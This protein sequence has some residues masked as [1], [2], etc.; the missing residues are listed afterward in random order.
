MNHHFLVRNAL[1]AAVLIGSAACASADS[2]TYAF[3]TTQ[4]NFSFTEPNLI[5]TD[6]PFSMAPFTLS[7][8]TYTAAF[9][10]TGGGSTL[11]VFSNSA[12]TGSCSTVVGGGGTAIILLFSN[13]PTNV[14]TFPAIG[15]ESLTITQTP[16]PASL[17][18]LGTGALGLLGTIRRRLLG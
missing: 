18:L 7:S 6:G 3:T 9:F 2:F 12:I 10:C 1:I 17:V 11:F 15:G 8:T 13:N 5:T 16:E 14:G 4:G